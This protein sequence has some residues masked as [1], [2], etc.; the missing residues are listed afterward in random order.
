MK[1]YVFS[2]MFSPVLT[3]SRPRKTVVFFYKFDDDGILNAY[4]STS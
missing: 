2:A 1:K 3:V 4:Y